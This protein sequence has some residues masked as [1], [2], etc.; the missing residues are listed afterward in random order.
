M[1][2]HEGSPWAGDPHAWSRPQAVSKRAASPLWRGGFRGSS[3]G[4]HGHE[5]GLAPETGT[6][7][8]P[9]LPNS[10]NPGHCEQW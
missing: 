4:R 3:G 8:R 1:S 6:S 7:A 9:A 2:R 5:E 10:R